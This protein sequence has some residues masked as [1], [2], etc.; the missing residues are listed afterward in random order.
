MP[1][2][3]HAVATVVVQAG[4]VQA[5]SGA[6][7]AAVA[8]TATPERIRDDL[9]A[10]LPGYMIPAHIMVFDELPLTG[11][12]KLDR[13]AI[14]AALV[15]GDTGAVT[16]PPRSDL[17]RALL[18]IVEEVLRAEPGTIGV[19]DDFFAAGGDSVLATAVIARVRDWLDAPQAG[20]ADIFAARTVAA[21]GERLDR[22]DSTAGRLEQVAAIYLEVSALDEFDDA[23]AG[24]S[25]T[26]TR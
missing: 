5:G 3:R 12:G 11:N 4:T 8:G 15:S 17:E 20:V 6:L 23:G 26:V 2:V 14:G 22:A 13:A 7:A 16:E 19:T 9:A 21:L 24:D 25:G 1:G 18:A 10:L